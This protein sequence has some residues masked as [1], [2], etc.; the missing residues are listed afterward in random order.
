MSGYV[1]NIEIKVPFDG[2]EVNV[3]VSPLTRADLFYLQALI[4]ADKSSDVFAYYAERLIE[5]VKI[6]DVQDAAGVLVPV[7]EWCGSAYHVPLVTQV[8]TAH[9]ERAV[10]SNP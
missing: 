3:T 10:P 4:E 8:M 6:H 2:R 5:Y 9:M 7:A 1:R